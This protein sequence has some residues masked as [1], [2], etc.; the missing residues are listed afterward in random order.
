MSSTVTH[1]SDFPPESVERLSSDK[2]SSSRSKSALN[3]LECLYDRYFA[4]LVDGLR[5][6]YGEGPPDPEEV[7]QQAFARLNARETL[8]DIDDLEGFVW[9]A[10]RNIIM[11]EKRAQK[12][13][14]KHQQDVELQ[15]FGERSECF[16]PQRVLIGRQQVA[17]VMEALE[18]MP[19]RRRKIFELH[20]IQ[21]LSLKEAGARCGVG[22]SA[23][24]RHIAIAMVDIAEEAARA[25]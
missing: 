12:T 19:E 2:W 22:Q 9:V 4:A 3:T 17:L 1:S 8:E 6:T 18:R 7:A 10:S 15:F 23:A 5:H 21:G 20:R 13:R 11:S 25:A 24:H 16:D 14:S